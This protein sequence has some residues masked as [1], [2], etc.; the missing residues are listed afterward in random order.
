MSKT[1]TTS[2]TILQNKIDFMAIIQA[3]NCNPNGDPLAENRPRT[4]SDGYGI[5]TDVCIKRKI[6]NRLQD[7]GLPIFVQ[8]N[9]RATDGYKSLA[10]RAKGEIGNGKDKKAYLEKACEMYTDVR[11]FGQV[12]AFGGNESVS[13]NVTGPVSIHIARS[14][15]PVE[16]NETQITKS[17]NGT[18]PNKNPDEKASDTF[19]S[20]R[21]ITHGLYVIK[22]SMNVQR[23]EKTGFTEDDAN[24]ILEALR[25]LFVNDA[26]AARPDGSMEVCKLYVWRHNC[27]DG[28]YP[29]AKIHNSLTIAPKYME[30]LPRSIDD[31]EITLAELPGITPEILDGI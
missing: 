1:K 5:I 30:R 3:T 14:V 12:F 28:Q 10:D 15:V 20:K 21:Y 18:T 16:V 29:A 6:R 13:I 31:Y 7:A 19:G 2:G 9:E 8:M 4:D 23:A 22:G 17:V 26:T 27:K 11:S 25:T 24:A